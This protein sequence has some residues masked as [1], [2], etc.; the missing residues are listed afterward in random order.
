[1][2]KPFELQSTALG[3]GSERSLS[4][5][6][7]RQALGRRATMTSEALAGMS[8]FALSRGMSEGSLQ[9][10]TGMDLADVVLPK[11]DRVPDHLPNSILAQL[12]KD[13]PG[14]IHLDAE[15]TIPTTHLAS[16]VDGMRVA[17]SVR[18]GFRLFVENT[19]LIAGRL[20]MDLEESDGEVRLRTWHPSRLL[21]NG[22]LGEVSML[23]LKRVFVEYLGLRGS[24]KRVDLR[25][26]R[27][28]VR[29]DYAA[30]FEAPIRMGQ[31][32]DALVFYPE[33]L[34]VVPVNADALAFEV[35]RESLHEAQVRQL[36]AGDPNHSRLIQL[37]QAIAANAVHGEFSVDAAVARAHMSLRTA[38][39]LMSSVG[40]SLGTAIEAVRSEMSIKLLSDPALTYE[41]IAIHL[42]YS[43]LR[44]FRRAFSRWTNT[45]PARFRSS[46]VNTSAKNASMV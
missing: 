26:G 43:D 44:S 40:L 37:C 41:E 21:D 13:N 31:A 1:M 20:E 32:C 7:V 10:I 38:Q 6:L 33:A 16:F 42:G 45:T 27:K 22:L 46:Q 4:H 2:A 29:S 25:Y 12:I 9:R 5:S 3:L 36:V 18:D 8:A 23:V 11:G 24:I 39:R 17:S 34:D 19:A 14:I 15:R 35:F 30:S 28:D